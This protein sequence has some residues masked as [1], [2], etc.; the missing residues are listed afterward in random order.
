MDFTQL[1]TRYASDR[2]G[3]AFKPF[4][5]PAGYIQ[6][7]FGVTEEGNVRPESDTV[8]QFNKP[9]VAQAPVDPNVERAEDYSMG[10]SP[11]TNVDGM[12]LAAATTR[13]SNRGPVTAPVAPEAL[14]G[15]TPMDTYIRT[16]ESGG[17]P[18]IGYHY[19]VGP[20]GK[21]KSTAY[22]AYGITAPAYRDIQMSDPYFRGRPI[23]S[24]SQT[25]QTRA[26]QVYKQVQQSQLRNLGIEPTDENLRAAQLLGAKGLKRYLEN[27]TFSNEA[28]RAN[29]GAQNL[30]RIL[31]ARMGGQAAPSSQPNL[32]PQPEAAPPQTEAAPPAPP[33]P[34]AAASD[35]QRMDTQGFE[36]L[37]AAPD[38]R[39]GA[40]VDKNQQYNDILTN[41]FTDPSAM[42]QL[43]YDKNV[44]E[45]TRRAA[46]DQLYLLMK[47]Q[48]DEQQAAAVVENA[49]ANPKEARK[50]TR[51]L[52]KPSEEGSYVKAYLYQ[53]LGMTD[54]AKAEQ[55]KLGA[56]DTWGQS[57]MF[58]KNGQQ[59]P[60]WIKYNGQGAPIKG[61]SAEGELDE[62]QLITAMSTK[63]VTTHTGKMIDRA[64]GR[65]Y[66]EQTTP[67]GIRLVEAGTNQP[68]VGDSKTLSPYGIGSDIE[69][70]N[71]I[72]LQ[73]LANKLR[74]EPTLEGQK[75]VA[76]QVMEQAA[77]NDRGDGVEIARARELLGQQGVSIDQRGEIVIGPRPAQGPATDQ[78]QPPAAVP[79]QQAP[80][81]QP[82]APQPPAPV[83][84]LR[85]AQEGDTPAITALRKQ[86][87]GDQKLRGESEA[88]YQERLKR[89]KDI[90][91]TILEL[92]S[93]AAKIP[94]EVEE[95]ERKEFIKTGE[96]IRNAGTDG[97]TVKNLR[98]QQID[99]LRNNPQIAGIMYGQGTQ[100][101]NARR[102]ILDSLSGRFSGQEGGAARADELGKINLNPNEKAALAEFANLTM[103]INQKTLRAASGPG[104]VS[105]A[106]QR[107]NKEANLQ[108][109]ERLEPMMV[110]NELFRSQFTSDLAAA[111]ADA[112]NRG[113]FK[114]RKEFDTYWNTESAK[115]TKQ[116]G[117]IYKARL[118]ML[119]PYLEAVQKNPGDATALQRRRDA[120]MH[121]MTVYPAPEYNVQTGKWDYKTDNARKAAMNAVLGR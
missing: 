82:P 100:Y 40:Q 97:S 103:N 76:R 60:V 81:P 105:D 98:K 7:R 9:I 23:E 116:Y 19:E 58:D 17:K 22:G 30:E 37:Q 35:G 53:R 83:T 39:A 54:L 3:R 119:K 68:F 24:L 46:S 112:L 115:L 49:M 47:Q 102:F 6:D 75:A 84:N 27:G 31:K 50:L 8:T 109:V 63:G 28:A 120:I 38:A 108:F 87:R 51:E 55:I 62:R 43:A 29:G 111:K 4:E 104:A 57:Y 73:E 77:R 10:V 95:T 42:A 117:A 34:Q 88:A 72:Q 94:L 92:Q 113:D 52:A 106:E 65:V 11:D 26:N 5:D 89:E 74:Y 33:P 25:E 21:R 79:A 18:D 78:R 2:L 70:K 64:T 96:E 16:Q 1:A 69:M 15:E 13:Q 85:Q 121:S 45:S 114:T 66:Y 67:Q 91:K 32:P 107:A 93:R 101:D 41:N 36:N 59:V 14:P 48:R 44:P 71:R 118:E 90:E 99:I 61:Y 12:Q 20:D 110:V 56:G 80:A 86:L